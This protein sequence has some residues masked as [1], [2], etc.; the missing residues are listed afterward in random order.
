[1]PTVH[2]YCGSIIWQLIGEK[3]MGREVRRRRGEGERRRRST[4]AKREREKERH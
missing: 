2:M 3:E 4:H 1:M